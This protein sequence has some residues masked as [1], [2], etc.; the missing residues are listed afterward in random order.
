MAK[1]AEIQRQLGSYN[2]SALYQQRPTPAEGGIFKREWFK[3]TVHKA[4]EGLQWKRGYDLAV[5]TRTA[6]C[7]TASFRVAIDQET[8][9]LYIAD[10]FRQ[11]IEFPEQQRYIMSRIKQEKDT[12][13]GIEKA[14]HGQALLQTLRRETRM[15]GKGLRG[16][17]VSKDKVTRAL[18]WAPLAEEGKVVLVRGPW[19]R[20]F[21]DEV[22]Q[23]PGGQ[24]DDQID[25]VS[26]AVTMFEDKGRKAWF[27]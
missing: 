9:I 11:R 4:P 21:L 20:E 19:N 17:D 16:I 3:K 2:F 1:L 12:E 6:S 8:G 27:F 15:L 13:H 22:C 14:L 18:K 7:F 26:L 5:S 10:G 25:A 23:F 24:F